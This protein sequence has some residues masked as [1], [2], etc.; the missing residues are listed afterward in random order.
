MA[1]LFNKIVQYVVVVAILAFVIWFIAN[2]LGYSLTY[3]EAARGALIGLLITDL[4]LWLF[5]SSTEFA[6]DTENLLRNRPP[7]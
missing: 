7:F 3:F 4:L 1:Y 6:K 2:L 5:N